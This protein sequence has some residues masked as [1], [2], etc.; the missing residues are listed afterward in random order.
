MIDA[1]FKAIVIAFI[2]AAFFGL[3]FFLWLE[4]RLRR[5]QHPPMQAVQDE[6]GDVRCG[7]CG[8]DLN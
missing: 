5:C 6:I 4:K 7:H 8:E 3:V 1:H 2:V